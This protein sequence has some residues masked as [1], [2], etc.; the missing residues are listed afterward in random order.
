[1]LMAIPGDTK[2]GSIHI[3]NVPQLGQKLIF[4]NDAKNKSHPNSAVL[5]GLKRPK[6]LIS[7]QVILL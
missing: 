2:K 3:S 6:I 7:N 5:L 4:L 1:M